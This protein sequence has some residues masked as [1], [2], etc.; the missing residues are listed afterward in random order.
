MKYPYLL[1][2]RIKVPETNSDEKRADARFDFFPS[3][4]IQWSTFAKKK[5]QIEIRKTL[6]DR[7]RII[8][9]GLGAAD[10]LTQKYGNRR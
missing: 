1:Y 10:L 6:A 2:Y 5:I 3:A 7:I 9:T 8:Y 4:P